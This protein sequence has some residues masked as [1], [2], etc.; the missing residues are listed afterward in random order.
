M[1]A[2]ARCRRKYE[3]IFNIEKQHKDTGQ[4]G[5]I[6]LLF[7]LMFVQGYKNLQTRH[8]NISCFY[9]TPL[10]VQPSCNSMYIYIYIFIYSIQRT[11]YT[12]AIYWLSLWDRR[13][14]HHRRQ[15]EFS[16]KTV[17]QPELSVCSLWK[18]QWYR[19]WTRFQKW[20]HT[21]YKCST[22]S[23]SL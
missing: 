16:S 23:W 22:L 17:T 4:S 10:F 9:H 6:V 5:S 18:L 21:T 15:T 12:W 20:G 2:V 19:W 8:D 7:P 1:A 11:Y 13:Q 3:T 14:R